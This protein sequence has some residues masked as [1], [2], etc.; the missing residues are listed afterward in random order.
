MI[1]DQDLLRSCSDITFEHRILIRSHEQVIHHCGRLLQ[2]GLEK[3]RVWVDASLKDLQ[4]DIYT[5]RF[6]LEH[7]LLEPLHEVP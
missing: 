7:Y 5:A 3:W 1:S 2:E 4:N 6:N